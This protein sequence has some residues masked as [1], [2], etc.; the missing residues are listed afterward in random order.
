MTP[1][2][3]GARLARVTLALL[4]LL[5]AHAVAV[6]AAGDLAGHWEGS[7]ALPTGK[8]AVLVDLQSDAAGLAGTISIPLQNAK[9]LPLT[10]LHAS[11]L[12]VGFEIAGVPGTPTF[13][14]TLTPDGRTISGDFTQGGATFRFE[15]ARSAKPAAAA[16]DAL[17][18][19]PRF[20]EAAIQ[21]RN[22]PGLAMAVVKDG[23][24]VFHRG[25][26]TRDLAAKTPVTSETLFAIGSCT[27]AFTSFV[28]ATLVDEGKL[29]WD[30][31]V[32]HFLPG[33]ALYDRTASEQLTPRDMLCHRSGLPRHDLLWYNNLAATRRDLVERLRYLEPNQPLRAKWQYNNLM[34][35]TAGY[36]AEQVTG[37]SWEDNVRQRIFAPLG[38]AHSNFTVEASQEAA[39]F[40]AP[41]RETD[42]QKLEKIPFR[43]ITNMGPAGS[44]N[45]TVDD[46]AEWVKLHLGNGRRGGTT[47]ISPGTLAELHAPQ[48]VI[49]ATQERPEITPAAY[50]MGWEVDTYR[51][52]PRVYHGGAIDG[53]AALVSL[54]PQDGLG[55]V[56]LA[57]RGGANGLEEDL[58]RHAADRILKLQP[59]D[60]NGEALARRAQGIAALKEARAK[61]ATLRKTGTKPAHKLEEYA[62]EYEHPG[63]GVVE[64]ATRGAGLEMTYHDIATPLKHWHYETWNGLKAADPTFEAMRIQF[65]TDFD[66]NVAA[67]EAP[68]E[69]QVANIVFTKRPEGRLSDPAYLQRFAGSYE[70]P[71]QK[72][73]VEVVGNGLTVTLPGQPVYHLVPG[74]GGQFTLKEYSVIA[75]AF[76]ADAQGK[77]TAVD[78]RQPEGVFTA[79]RLP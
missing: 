54:F 41:Y 15:L 71:G 43:P 39:D 22:V 36:L 56:V 9:N 63:Y 77:V 64:V 67:L 62:G 72:V 4:A 20:V 1:R 75:L 52:H 37:K 19:F 11:A 32:A 60:W 12:E 44:I 57:N 59:I 68:F 34:F 55:V 18:D 23:E 17:G 29:D 27:K 45:S 3:P 49:G 35:L 48:M 61:R 40:A 73:V 47:L 26:G 16:Q 69:P 24:V 30:K 38:M 65:R 53:F 25:F 14:G 46:M 79:K 28:I 51:G 31:P 8:L 21:A 76:V 50:A 58:V 5:A 10:N 74:L 33:F 7:I 66:G 78:F 70:L 13:K 42:D 2:R 6:L